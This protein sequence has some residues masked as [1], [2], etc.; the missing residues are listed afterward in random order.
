MKGLDHKN[1][2]GEFSQDRALAI[3]GHE[4][5]NVL[6]GLLGMTELLRDA[7]LNPEQDRWLRAIEHSG[8]QMGQ[9]ID[10]FHHLNQFPRLATRPEQ[11]PMDGIKML[12]QVVIAHTPAARSRDN[13]LVLIVD[14]AIPR[15]WECDACRVRQLV[16]NL[17]GNAIRFTRSG[18][19]IV[20][21]FAQGEKSAEST[22]LGIKITDSG[23]GIDNASGERIF[24]AGQKDFHANGGPS[25][26][27]GLGLYICRN[28]VRSM[29]GRILWS[30]P[31]A[32]GTCFEVTIPGAL[33]PHRGYSQFPQSMLLKQ[34]CCRLQLDKPIR[35]GVA[36]FLTRLGVDWYDDA[37]PGHELPSPSL[38]ID[39]TA[40]RS[41][42]I[43]NLPGLK[44]RAKS[45]AGISRQGKR[46]AGPV[47]LSSLGILLI[48]MALEWRRQ[49]ATPG[50]I[51]G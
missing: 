48:E 29:R 9:L 30:R 40:D 19:V 42:D 15:F 18:E 45:P 27:K 10:S 28:I 41:M 22:T 11:Q 1:P 23:P 31:K 20:D 32:G 47:L 25:A 7:R 6:N 26:G 39:V 50:G 44:L 36:N 38:L 24:E 16:E 8:R 49:Q 4:L 5:G 46:L 43:D 34:V 14:P 33:G 51:P 35:L 12:E 13:N 3:L 17:L 21:V 37:C 2:A